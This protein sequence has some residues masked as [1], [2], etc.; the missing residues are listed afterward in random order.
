MKT[1]SSKI[2]PFDGS[3]RDSSEF[4]PIGG[5]NYGDNSSFLGGDSPGGLVLI[6]VPN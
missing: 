2:L 3:V 6:G 4:S 1:P 5:L